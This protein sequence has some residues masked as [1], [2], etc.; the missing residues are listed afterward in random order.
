MLEHTFVH[1]PGVGA[2]TE[3]ALWDQGVV[4]WA[5]AIDL[6]ACP[7]GFS[8]ARW[9]QS[10]R[11]IEDSLRSLQ[12][13][14][15]RHF[16]TSLP[17][18]EH[19]RAYRDFRHSTAYLDIETT[20]CHRSSQVTVVGLYDGRRTR[21][22]IAGDNLDQ[23]PEVLDQYAMIVSF[24]GS[25]FDLPYLRRSFPDL[26]GGHLHLDLMH[27]LRRL[28]LK[29]GLKAIERHLGIERD[30]DL[31]G[32]DGWDAVRLWREYQRGNAASLDTLVRYNAADIENLE[33]LAE[34]AYAGVR[35]SMGLPCDAS[36]EGAGACE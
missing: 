20:G 32:L 17:T 21:T 24:N 1:I 5:D 19:W 15:H 9:G 29:G 28:G 31:A 13:H 27:A 26:P 23:F 11:F 30:D 8:D 12:R 4:T 18:S 14:D 35:A 16:A 10:C 3:R 34:R 25:S 33:L 7:V 2:V 22:F 6:G 36:G